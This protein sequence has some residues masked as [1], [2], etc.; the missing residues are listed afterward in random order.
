MK[1][2]CKDVGLNCDYAAIGE[3]RAEVMDMALTHVVDIY[4]SL[5][6]YLTEEQAEEMEAKLKSLIREDD[7]EIISS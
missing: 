3:T 7:E 6:E 5:F 4:V 2:E 1:F